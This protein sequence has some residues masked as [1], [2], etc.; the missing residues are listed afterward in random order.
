M[1]QT[2]LNTCPLLARRHCHCTYKPSERQ[3]LPNR[4]LD[5]Q[6]PTPT[7]RVISGA[8]VNIRNWPTRLFFITALPPTIS[9]P[10]YGK[11]V[12]MNLTGPYTELNHFHHDIGQSMIQESELR[13][14]AFPIIVHLIIFAILVACALRSATTILIQKQP[15]LRL[16]KGSSSVSLWQAVQRAHVVI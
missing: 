2:D 11:T 9:A 12:I 10:G 7:Y 15:S 8:F 3:C 1:A 6:T 4:F 5:T 13:R 16:S 14:K